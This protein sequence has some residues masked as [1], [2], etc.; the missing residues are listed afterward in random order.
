MSRY[1]SSGGGLGS[2]RLRTK[3]RFFLRSKIAM[4]EGLAW[5]VLVL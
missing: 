1:V 2:W 3:T 5:C 4:V